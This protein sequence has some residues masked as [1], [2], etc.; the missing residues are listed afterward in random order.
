MKKVKDLEVKVTYRVGFGNFK[1]PGK[2]Y[3]QLMKAAFNGDEIESD[4]L[5][6]PDAAEW[7]SNNIREK[8]CTSWEAEIED[9]S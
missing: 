3:E 5:D 1:M 7:L 4:G 6:Y 2:V 9:I 8:D